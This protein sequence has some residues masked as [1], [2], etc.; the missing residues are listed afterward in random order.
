MWI[1][2]CLHWWMGKER[3]QKQDWWFRTWPWVVTNCINYLEALPASVNVK[4]FIDV[5]TLTGFV[6]WDWC[7]KT[8]SKSSENL[9]VHTKFEPI[10]SHFFTSHG[11]KIKLFQ[12]SLVLFHPYLNSFFQ[13]I[14]WRHD[15][16]I[17]A[18]FEAFS[19][20]ILDTKSK[21]PTGTGC[22]IKAFNDKFSMSHGKFLL[23]YIV[24]K[25]F[26]LDIEL[27]QTFCLQTPKVWLYLTASFLPQG[28]KGNIQNSRPDLS[29]WLH[30]PEM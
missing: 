21:A 8:T 18:S 20:I 4:S 30:I 14:L 26:E 17:M 27:K 25:C 2:L 6:C 23:D 10:N 7:L 16:P 1:W 22:Q 24:R 12:V 29:Q 3:C 5:V 9:L 19:T 15:C 13:E 28:C 11:N